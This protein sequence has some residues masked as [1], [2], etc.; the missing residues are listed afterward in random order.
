MNKDKNKK[1]TDIPELSIFEERKQ[2][3]VSAKEVLEIAKK[4]EEKKLKEGYHY[5][6]TQDGKTFILTKV[7][8]K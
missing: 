1:R 4:Q 5:V 8:K 7:K 6:A 3:K 2:H